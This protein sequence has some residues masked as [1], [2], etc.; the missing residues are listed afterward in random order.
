MKIGVKTYD[1]PLFLKE[2]VDKVDFF[3]VMAIEGKDYSFLKSFNK[4]VVVHA[5]HDSFGIN[6][7]D[8]SKR[9]NKL[10]PFGQLC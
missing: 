4:P 10:M 1:N 5:Q 9:E 7:A 6:N 2:F 3:E 8:K